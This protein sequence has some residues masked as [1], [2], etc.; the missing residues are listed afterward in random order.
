MEMLSNILM[1]LIQ[2]YQ[3][4]GNILIVLG[5]FLPFLHILSLCLFMCISCIPHAYCLP[6][7]RYL[8]LYPVPLTRTSYYYPWLL[9]VVILFYTEY[10]LL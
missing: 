4:S 10:T 9:V 1:N 8:V 6:P 2:E 7:P 5:A 3:R